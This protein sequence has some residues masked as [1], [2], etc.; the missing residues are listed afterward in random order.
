[1]L[2]LAAIWL[3][4]QSNKY[5][6]TLYERNGGGLASNVV[7]YT[8]ESKETCTLDIPF[9]KSSISLMYLIKI[10][11]CIHPLTTRIW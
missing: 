4:S 6:V 11:V 9:R 5:E 10:K 7:D 1:M 8:C 3:L 2:G